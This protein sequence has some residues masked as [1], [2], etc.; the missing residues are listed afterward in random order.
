VATRDTSLTI[1]PEDF[2]T[3]VWRNEDSIAMIASTWAVN[4]R[5]DFVDYE[6]EFRKN[7]ARAAANFGCRPVMNFSA[8]FRN[9]KLPR[10]KAN[11]KRRHPIDED[12]RFYDWFKPEDR[13]YFAHM[14][15][16]IKHDATGFC[17]TSWDPDT[18]M[19]IVDL[20]M[21]IPVPVGEELR[22]RHNRQRV[23]E[24]DAMGFEFGLVTADQYQSRE[25]LQDLADAGIPT[26]LFS[27]DRNSFSYD[28]AK[29]LMTRD[30]VDYYVYEPLIK[31][32]EELLLSKGKVDHP[33][34][35]SKDVA[36]SFAAAVCHAWE[37]GQK[38]VEAGI[39]WV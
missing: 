3:E 37:H 34:D 7:Y 26:D 17:V 11:H 35:G 12:G 28:T 16:S 1:K 21:S 2:P 33:E 8:Y 29:E 20:L 6:S 36:D 31:E 25:S 13:V 38:S 23:L 4:E 9:R 32:L 15:M 18:E 30:I 19:V 24:L 22:L 10:L 27:V 39:R 14:D 5:Q